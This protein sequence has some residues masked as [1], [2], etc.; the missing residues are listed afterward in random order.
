[1]WVDGSDSAFLSPLE[2]G[3]KTDFFG[4]FEPPWGLEVGDIGILTKK[5]IKGLGRLF[6]KIKK[7]VTA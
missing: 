2:S 5:G 1:M 6:G 3:S 7:Y 4:V